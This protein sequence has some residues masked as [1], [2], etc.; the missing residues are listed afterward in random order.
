MRRTPSDLIWFLIYGVRREGRAY[1]EHQREGLGGVEKDE[2]ELLGDLVEEGDGELL[3]G[4][5]ALRAADVDIDAARLEALLDA[6][7]DRGRTGSILAALGVDDNDRQGVAVGLHEA[8][9]V[10]LR[11]QQA[12]YGSRGK[13]RRTD[14]VPL[15]KR[16]RVLLDHLE[17][18]L[19]VGVVKVPLE[20]VGGDAV[21]V[22]VLD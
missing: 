22:L 1:P 19:V 7:S 12:G 5:V 4:D 20:E 2:V 8:E 16:S 13:G 17:L 10:A 14:G 18:G 21:V 15:T 6:P 9:D 11:D 3:L